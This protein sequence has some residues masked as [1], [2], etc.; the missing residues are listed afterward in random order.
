MLAMVIPHYLSI[1]R[2]IA[3]HI[4]YRVN[5]F[6]K[7]WLHVLVQNGPIRGH[8]AGRLHS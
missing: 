2:F 1:D 6:S 3:L 5:W 7:L 8:A 4:V